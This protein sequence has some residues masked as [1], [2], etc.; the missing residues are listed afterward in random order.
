MNKDLKSIIQK[1]MKNSIKKC[2]P[3]LA[4]RD[5]FE[6]KQQTTNCQQCGLKKANMWIY[7]FENDTEWKSF[8]PGLECT[9]CEIANVITHGDK[10]Q[11][12]RRKQRLMSEYWYIPRDLQNAGF[13]SFSKRNNAAVENALKESV[14][15]YHNFKDSPEEER[16]N[17]VFIGNP[18][19]GKTHLSVAIARNLK[20][21]GFV[22]GFITTG[23]LLSLFKETYQKGNNKTEND[24]FKDL[25]RFDILV[26]DDLGSEVGSKDEF[27]WDKK[28]L[29][30]IINTRMGK[31][32]I[33]TTNYDDKTLPKVIG[34]RVASRINI[35][36]KFV[37]LFTDDF[38]KSKRIV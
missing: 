35:K 21:A 20:E 38:R 3:E 11:N 19:T 25:K 30:E 6:F 34:E 27:S 33:Y 9:D 29:F 23:R 2:I 4:D 28:M 17:L 1:Q 14:D 5:D 15:Y 32:T 37:N 12:F 7:R 26:L 22:V 16:Y 13:S 18:G 8:S 36:T 24:I 31:P 10:E